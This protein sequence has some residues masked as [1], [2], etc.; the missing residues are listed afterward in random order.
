MSSLDNVKTHIGGIKNNI[1]ATIVEG[2]DKK[3]LLSLLD[4]IHA[5]TEKSAALLSKAFLDHYDKYNKNRDIDI[6]KYNNELKQFA[7]LNDKYKIEVTKRD[8]L[9]KEYSDILKITKTLKKNYKGSLS[10]Q[11]LFDTIVSKIENVFK[12]QNDEKLS[13]PNTQCAADVLKAHLS[14]NRV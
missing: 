5:S 4:D 9:W 14:G 12:L 11:K 8:L 10:D 7:E 13:T 6:L 1:H 2:Q 3:G